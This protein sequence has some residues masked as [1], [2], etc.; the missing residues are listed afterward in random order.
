MD[1]VMECFAEVFADGYEKLPF[2][3]DGKTVYIATFDR[4]LICSLPFF[5]IEDGGEVYLADEGECEEIN[6]LLN[7]H[8]M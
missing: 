6:E 7:K 1:A 2:E 3:Y 5:A 4:P 8:G